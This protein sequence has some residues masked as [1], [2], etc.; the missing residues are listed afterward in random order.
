MYNLR[1]MLFCLVFTC[2]TGLFCVTALSGKFTNPGTDGPSNQLFSIT[3]AFTLMAEHEHLALYL[4]EQSLAIRLLNKRTGYIWSSDIDDFGEDYLNDRWK[5]FINS[6][7]TIEYFLARRNTAGRTA[8]DRTATEESFL[9]SGFSAAAVTKI[10]KGFRVRAVFGNSG[11]GISYETLLTETGIETALNPE[12]IEE[13][14]SE[15]IVSVQFYPFLGA[16]RHGTQQGYFV[17]PDGDGSLIRFDRVYTNIT[18]NYQKRYFG[19]DRGISPVPEDA[20]GFTFKESEQLNYPVYGIVHGIHANALVN[21]ILSGAAFAELLV[22]PAGVRTNYYFISNRYLLRQPY[23]YIVST[24][25]QTTMLT[26][27]RANIR[28]REGITVLEEERADY[29][30][31]AQTYRKNLLEQGLLR[32]RIKP[33]EPDIPLYLNVLAGA[34]NEGIF[35]NNPILMTSIPDLSAIT[36]DLKSR[37]IGNLQVRYC[38]MWRRELSGS[39]QDR[40]ALWPGA[41]SLGELR[42]LDRRL[43]ETGGRLIIDAY[44]GIAFSRIR[45]LDLKE[46]VIRNI[47]KQYLIETAR[48]GAVTKAYHNLNSAGTVKLL[49]KDA[50]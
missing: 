26:P 45:G 41:G 49:L 14:E 10:P 15:R 8:I 23:T 29:V 48:H 27:D 43:R 13:T 44:P 35:R 18:R 36:A 19:A 25:N 17:L 2:I 37:E 9:E 30:G 20:L 31:I 16:V 47:N 34:A 5:G 7:V 42:E 39:E 22:Y 33:G 4:N 40:Y 6:G 3:G 12:D 38:N 1:S 11:I 24:G 50:E 46:E 32:A 28:I 21:E